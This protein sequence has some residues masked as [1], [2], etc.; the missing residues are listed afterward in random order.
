MMLAVNYHIIIIYYYCTVTMQN[1]ITILHGHSI[2][3]IHDEK[4]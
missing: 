2:I 3:T 1:Y 4:Q